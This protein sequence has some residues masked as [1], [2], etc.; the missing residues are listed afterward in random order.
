MNEV[1]SPLVSKSINDEILLA[2]SF[3]LP[4]ENNTQIKL[5]VPTCLFQK[6]VDKNIQA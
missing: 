5:S 6:V 2:N 1:N 3:A 4:N